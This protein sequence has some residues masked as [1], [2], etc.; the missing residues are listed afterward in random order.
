MNASVNP[1]YKHPIL[2]PPDHNITRMIFV[3][4]HIT[5]LHSGPQ[6]LLATIRTKYWPI[7]GKIIARSVVKNCVTCSKNMPRPAKHL[8]GNLPPCRVQPSR[9][10]ENCGI[11]YCGPLLYRRV[12]Q[13]RSQ[14]VKAYVALFVCMATKAIHIELVPDMTTKKFLE[15][16]Q[17]MIARRG[18]IKHIYCDNA[19]NFV[20]A[21]NELHELQLLF[22][23]DTHQYQVHKLCT[24]VGITWHFIPPRSPHFGGLWEAGVKSVKHHL[25]RVLGTYILP[26]DELETLLVK[27]EA[28]VNSRPITEL[29]N[30]PNDLNP[31]TPAHFLVGQSLAS[32]PVPDVSTLNINR[33][34][35]W[36]RI[37]QLYQIFWRR[38]SD[39][40]L[41][42]LQQR[43]KW[44]KDYTPP[45]PGSLVLIKEDFRPPLHWDLGRIVELHNGSDGIPRVATIRTSKG[46]VKRALVKLCVLADL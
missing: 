24:S 29:S 7:K 45:S 34:D 38:W 5:T 42:T 40:Y 18:A 27:I 10:F 6:A 35:H 31:L 15:A 23:S 30:D 14:P 46:L 16:L 8:M 26:Y 37:Q 44:V 22:A 11:D 39:E 43:T 2:L 19:T 32:F 3:E 28:C 1:E 36:Q 9:P 13:R 25:K 21:K 20:G 4:T 17:R 12:S 41:S 33:L